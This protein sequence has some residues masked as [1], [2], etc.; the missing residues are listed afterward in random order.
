M[1]D[2]GL[3]CQRVNHQHPAAVQI[4]DIV[5]RDGAIAIEGS[6][7]VAAQKCAVFLDIGNQQQ[8]FRIGCRCL[9][10][11]LENM[12]LVFADILFV[13]SNLIL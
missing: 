5:H 8:G 4:F 1:L 10:L 13:Q 2:I 3:C 6:A 7:E 9:T 11:K 12:A